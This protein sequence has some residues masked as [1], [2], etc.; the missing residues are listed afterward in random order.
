MLDE[1]GARGRAS[2]CSSRAAPTVAGDFHRAGLVDRY[3]VYLAPGALRRRRRPAAVRRAGR[4]DDRRRV[5]G[6][7]VGVRLGD[8]L[9]I[10]LEPVDLALRSG[11]IARRAR[12]AR[13][14]G[15]RLMFTGIVEELGTVA[16]PRRAA[17]RIA[18]TAVLDDAE[19]R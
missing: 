9:R 18:A 13:P 1:L 7:I 8:D 16:S 4:A 2:R 3:V 11:A 15:E 5:A 14:D 12:R 6:R 10:D 17:L 19:H